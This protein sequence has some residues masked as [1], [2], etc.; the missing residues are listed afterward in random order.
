MMHHLQRTVFGGILLCLAGLA[1]G[2]PQP[3][4]YP[5]S[6]ELKF[7]HSMPKRVVVKPRGGQEPQAFWYITYTVT[8]LSS[9]EQNFLPVFELMT[10]DGQVIR[11]DSRIPQEVLE[12]IRRREKNPHLE[13]ATEIAGTLRVGEDQARDGVA[14][15]R[16]P[17][18]RMGRFIVFVTG[19]SGEAVI[20]KDPKGNELT[21]V[22][23]DGQKR[24]IVLWKSLQLDYHM[25]GDEKNPGN[26]VVELVE[27][28]WVMR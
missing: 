12:T 5:I 28:K 4:P 9:A 1:M 3:S 20:L 22:D 17:N 25:P 15:W 27:R 8:N 19:L 6:W 16:E 11:S 10:Q 7:E 24:P 18:P 13:S 21:Q 26:D 2:A 23:K 14:I